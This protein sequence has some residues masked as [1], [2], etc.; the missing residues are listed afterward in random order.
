M[1]NLK[2][3]ILPNTKL[4]IFTKVISFKR[5]LASFDGEGRIEGKI[6]CRAQFKLILPDSVL[7]PKKI[8]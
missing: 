8:A 5:G 1:Q 2:K 7:S 6:A 3:K 4:E